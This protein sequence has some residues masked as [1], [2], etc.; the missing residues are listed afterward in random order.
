MHRQNFYSL[1]QIWPKW[2]SSNPSTFTCFS[3]N[4]CPCHMLSFSHGIFPFLDDNQKSSYH[5]CNRAYK[6]DLGQCYWAFCLRKWVWNEDHFTCLWL[7]IFDIIVALLNFLP[8]WY[9][10]IPVWLVGFEF[11]IILTISRILGSYFIHGQTKLW[12]LGILNEIY[13]FAAHVEFMSW[14]WRHKIKN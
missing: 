12:V 13:M 9:T 10:R 7:E 11:I 14:E 3:C 4:H 1:G 6:R 5:L 8:D 2:P